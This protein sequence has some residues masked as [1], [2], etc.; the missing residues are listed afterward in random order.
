MGCPA[1]HM[2]LKTVSSAARFAG[3]PAGADAFAVGGDGVS[4]RDLKFMADYHLA[5]GITYFNIHGLDYTIEG[6]SFDE[7]PPSQSMPEW[8]ITGRSRRAAS[9]RRHMHFSS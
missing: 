9:L 2:G 5:M 3:K 6:E 1:H 7:T 8:N 4:L